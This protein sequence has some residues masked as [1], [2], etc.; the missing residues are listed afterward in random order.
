MSASQ[1]IPQ[2]AVAAKGLKELAGPLIAIIVGIF[3]AILDSTAVNV[4]VPEL[5]KQFNSTLSIVQWTITGYTL[6]QAAVIPLAGWLSDRFGARKIYI[7]SIIM[8]TLGSLLCT[9]ATDAPQ[10]IAFRVL[11][12]LGGGMVMP[13]AMAM[14]YRLSPRDKVGAIMGIMGMPILLAPAI[15]PVLSGY[16][17]D[18]VQWQWIFLINLPVGIL[19]VFMALKFVPVLESKAST[20]FDFLGVLL[21]PIAFASISYGISEGGTSWTSTETITGITVGI[22]ALVLFV[23]VELTRKEQPLLE[24]RVFKSMSF[25]R[26]IFTQWTMQFV[27]FGVI[28]LVPFYMQRLM[29]MTAFEA[30]YWTLPQ[31]LA[32]GFLMP[33]GGRLYDKIGPRPLVIT[34][35]TFVAIGAFLISKVTPQDAAS[36]FLIPRILFGAGM[37]M[38]FLSLNTFLMQSAPQNLVSRVTSLTS[39]LQQVVTSLSVAGLTTILVNRTTAHIDAGDAPQAAFPNAF[40]DVYLILMCIA[41][42]GILLGATLTKIQKDPKPVAKTNDV[43]DD[44]APMIIAE[45]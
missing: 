33:V 6:A 3:M 38:S 31:A 2:E 9:L 36:A 14:I 28:F 21:G 25:T 32:A 4:A 35:L 1:G 18:Y 8:F 34:G 16:L 20:S 13:I 24:L 30:G 11:Q 39:A 12:G 17:V 29:G 44:D 19:A 5:V 26:G 37:G 42:V 23:I 41:I 7:L 27:M 43:D 22:V 45:M 40:Q 10:L 15:G